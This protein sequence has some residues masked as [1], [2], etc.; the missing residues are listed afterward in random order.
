M[1]KTWFV[2]GLL[3]WAIGMIPGPIEAAKPAS[4]GKDRK[5]QT[6]SSEE[7]PKAKENK[8]DPFKE[9]ARRVEEFQK[10]ERRRM[11]IVTNPTGYEAMKQLYHDEKRARYEAEKH[12]RESFLRVMNLLGDTS[13]ELERPSEHQSGFESPSDLA[14]DLS[15]GDEVDENSIFMFP[16]KDNYDQI[17]LKACNH[18]RARAGIPPLHLSFELE[19]AAVLRAVEVTQHLSNTRPNGKS[20]KTLIPAAKRAHCAESISAGSK[21]V[22]E[23]I[24]EFLSSDEYR[25]YLLNPDYKEM[26]V[27]F[28]YDPESEH[29]YY[30]VRFFTT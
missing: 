24:A 3:F 14:N 8:K 17:M 13:S 25:K 28:R 23:A 15:E 10:E 18:E 20:F 6:V 12:K 2:A 16:K 11:D 30:W 21:T 5:E 4:V 1:R 22:E 19:C 29:K 27:G 26:G 9:F 7:E